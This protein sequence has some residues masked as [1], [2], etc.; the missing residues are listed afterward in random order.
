ML[1]VERTSGSEMQEDAVGVNDIARCCQDTRPPLRRAMQTM[2]SLLQ[3]RIV[4][5]TNL[6][7]TDEPIEPLS[8]LN[9]SGGRQALS[10]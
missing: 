5:C 8:Y 3:S 6:R 10:S 1:G 2:L 7:L 4:P 9:Q